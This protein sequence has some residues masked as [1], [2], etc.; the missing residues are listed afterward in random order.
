MHGIWMYRCMRHNKYL[1]ILLIVFIGLLV[2]GFLMFLFQ[3]YQI[4]I[5]IDKD[6][7]LII[8]LT[9]CLLLLLFNY[10]KSKNIS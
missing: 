4:S 9:V 10:L 3:K 7:A 1:K 5:G 2:Y 8:I 6:I